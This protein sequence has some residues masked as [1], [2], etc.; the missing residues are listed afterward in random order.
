MLSRRILSLV[1]I[2]STVVKSVTST[3]KCLSDG[4]VV[5]VGAGPSSLF[6]ANILLQQNPTVSVQ[7]V[8]KN[9]R[10]G[11]PDQGAFGFGIGCRHEKLLEPI[12][13][14]WEQLKE[15]S[16]PTKFGL[17]I[18][19]RNDLCSKLRSRLEST[20]PERFKILYETQCENIDFKQNL[21][22]LK[23]GS[24]IFYDLLVGADGANSMV[25]ASIRK[26]DAGYAEEHYFRPILWK[27]LR[28]PDQK[29]EVDP[30]AVIPIS[31]GGFR[32]G[33]LLPRYPEGHTIL[34][35][36]DN[37]NLQNPEG[38][39]DEEGLVKAI[40][41]G[42]QAK[43]SVFQKLVY[44]KR[45]RTEESLNIEFD[46]I[47]LKRFLQGQANREHILKLRKYHHNENVALM[48]DAAHA[49]YSLLGQGA[50]CGFLTASMLAQSLGREINISTALE[51]YS[52]D[53]VPAANA[54]VDL[55]LV[56][57][58][59]DGGLLIKLATALLSL[60]DALRGSVLFKDVA[61][62]NM[63]YQEILKRNRLL[64]WICK[65]VFKKR[66]VTAPTHRKI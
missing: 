44:F 9:S 50:A 33:G 2:L 26:D 56:T 31:G 34:A 36:W 21:V 39:H 15:V 62:T 48:G 45:Q 6:F 57:H 38:V 58:V 20:Y 13:G 11:T 25:R 8:E 41:T 61:H 66:R 65:Q 35:F 55:N 51:N 32:T 22:L 54:I 1:L 63:P 53:A 12:P 49:M 30:R 19:R 7:I 10:D 42:L 46:D 40:T 16:A 18:I 37:L 14:M 5:I 64:I 52:N 59:L 23:N 4:Q 27:S 43:M 24:S 3:E 17:R 28:L 47:E 60:F 29:G